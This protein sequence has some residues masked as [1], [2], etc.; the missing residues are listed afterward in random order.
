LLKDKKAEGVLG[1]ESLPYITLQYRQFDG[2]ILNLFK[3]F[4]KGISFIKLQ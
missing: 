3:K 1:I 4:L 2:K